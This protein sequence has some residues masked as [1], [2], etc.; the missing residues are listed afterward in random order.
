MIESKI[1]NKGEN[2]KKEDKTASERVKI[3]EKESKELASKLLQKMRLGSESVV[4][5][6]IEKKKVTIV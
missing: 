3:F 5:K 4:S 1:K 6:V 2:E